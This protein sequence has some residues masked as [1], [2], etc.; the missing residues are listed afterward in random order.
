VT[1]IRKL[2]S[3]WIVE[4]PILVSGDIGQESDTFRL[5]FGNGMDQWIDLLYDNSIF[6]CSDYTIVKI[7]AGFWVSG[8]SDTTIPIPP[9]VGNRLPLTLP[10]PL[11]S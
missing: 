9:I 8:S 1:I 3:E 5:K 10:A 11:G 4:N 7:P 2:K 6:I